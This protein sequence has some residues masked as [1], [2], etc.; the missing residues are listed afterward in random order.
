MLISIKSPQQSE[1]SLPHTIWVRN[2][3]TF[4]KQEGGMETSHRY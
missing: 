1:N 3:L 2:A 4:C